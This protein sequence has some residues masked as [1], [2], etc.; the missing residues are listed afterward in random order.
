M[1]LFKD[2]GNILSGNTDEIE[3]WDKIGATPPPEDMPR[4]P[5]PPPLRQ[6][7]PLVIISLPYGDGLE[8]I[9]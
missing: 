1:S 7:S 5:A 9:H 3:W 2:I 4:I 6:P 8:T